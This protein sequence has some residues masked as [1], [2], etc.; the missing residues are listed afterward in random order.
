MTKP[1]Q[2]MAVGGNQRARNFFKQ[3][4]WD[5]QGSDKIAGKYTSR[6][7]QLYKELLAREAAALGA[8][9]EGAA[10]EAAPSPSRSLE[11][12]LGNTL[13]PPAGPPAPLRA[14]WLLPHHHRLHR[15]RPRPLLRPPRHRRLW[16]RS[17]QPP[18]SNQPC[19]S[20]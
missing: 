13:A 5:E 18:L 17:P 6:A 11:V 4:G 8:A 15:P 7:A 9:S 19:P 10:A 14:P 16:P 3:H 12:R 2:L 1:L 20:R